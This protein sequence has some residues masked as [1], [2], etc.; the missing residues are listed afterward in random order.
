MVQKILAK[1]ESLAFKF[2]YWYMKSKITRERVGKHFAFFHPRPTG[3]I[4]LQEYEQRLQGR[5]LLVLATG[6]FDVLHSEHQKFL[7]AAKNLGGKLLVGLETDARVRKLKGPGRPVNSL[8]IRLHNLRRL[9]IADQVF[10]LPKKFNHPEDYQKFIQKL[11]PDILAVSATTPF[12][13]NKRQLMKIYGG[14]VVVVLPHNPKIS[15]SKMIKSK[16]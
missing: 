3:K 10:S 5:N 11:R 1:L 8:K 7:K 2:Q 6:C 15:T 4:V 14:K 9:G 12:L 16:Q 13:W